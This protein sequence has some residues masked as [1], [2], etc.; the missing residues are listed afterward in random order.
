MTAF[1]IRPTNPLPVKIL[2]HIFCWMLFISYELVSLY[3]VIGRLEPVSVYVLY[4]SLNIL[5][6]YSHA[7][8]LHYSFDQSPRRLAEGALLLLLEFLVYVAIKSVVDMALETHPGTLTLKVLAAEKLAI[9]NLIRAI[10]FGLLATFYW[11]AGRVGYFRQQK[12]RAEQQAAELGQQLALAENAYLRQQLNPHMLFNALNFIYHSVYKHSVDGSRCVLL[13]S[14]I[15]RFGLESAAPDG[16]TLLSAE[17]EQLNNLLEI[18]RYRFGGKLHLEVQF[19]AEPGQH[20][21]IPLI[22]FTLTENLFKHGHLKDPAHPAQLILSIDQ[23]GALRYY[24]YNLKKKKNDA[25]REHLGLKNTRL[26]LD[27]SYPGSY[28]LSVNESE[29][30]YE[31]TLNLQL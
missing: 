23:T 26:R 2:L 12:A 3:L 10:Y 28:R 13:L 1:Q 9:P 15:L 30:F 19:P 5:F 27:Q 11:L 24:S 4:Y 7:G 31:L 21:I 22:L 25:A 16:K 18:N 14:D 20:R 6:F 17:I 29:T 8:L